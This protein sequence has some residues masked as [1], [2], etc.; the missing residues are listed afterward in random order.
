M[1]FQEQNLN[2]V[3]YM[4]TGAIGA[5]HAFTTRWGGVSE[6]IFESLNL[7]ENREDNEAHVRENFARICSA[8]RVDPEC[9]VFSNQVHGDIIRR[10]TREDIHTLFSPRALRG[11]RTYQPTKG[12]CP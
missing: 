11:G 10:V 1:S 5:A 3:V 2:G 8:I 6:G 12:S 9:L 4:T 7:A